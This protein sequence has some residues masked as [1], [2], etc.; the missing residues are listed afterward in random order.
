MPTF[1]LGAECHA[2][3]DRLFSAI[4]SSGFT[5]VSHEI[6]EDYFL[7]DVDVEFV[8]D[9]TLDNIHE[10]L[11]T[12]ADNDVMKFTLCQ[13]SLNENLLVSN[14][15]IRSGNYEQIES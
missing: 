4:V 11:G 14:Y 9:T 7:Q 2:Q 1:S 3:I 12:I 6:K 10:I 8:A 13:S 15:D 5:I